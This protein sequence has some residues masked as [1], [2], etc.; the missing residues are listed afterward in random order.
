MISV[1][2]LSNNNDGKIFRDQMD[3]NMI[4]EEAD[5]CFLCGMML[6]EITVEKSKENLLRHIF[7]VKNTVEQK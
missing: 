7:R 5:E 3:C 2:R 4:S 1:K 6:K